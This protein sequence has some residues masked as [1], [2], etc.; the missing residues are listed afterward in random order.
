LK[1]REFL[2]KAAIG[3]AS[4]ASLPVLGGMPVAQAQAEPSPTAGA[5][6]NFHF[7]CSSRA[8]TV[9]NVKHVVFMTGDGKFDENGII[10]GGVYDHYDDTSASPKTILSSGPW[11]AK[12]LVSSNII[13]R[14]WMITAG[15][16]EMEIN[17]LQEKPSPAVIPA[18]LKVACNWPV[19]NLFVPN[20]K[21]GIT[22][23]IPDSDFGPFVPVVPPVGFTAFSTDK[24]AEDKA[25]DDV[26]EQLQTT[27]GLYLPTA[28]IVPSVIA[29]GLAFALARSR[30]KK[31][32]AR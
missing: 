27:S 19:G 16:A 26:K 12:R 15:V 8:G 25:L 6:V 10:G 29:G 18:T 9:A 17:L 20:E 31:K 28:A 30:R 3:T 1:R 13:G 4:L 7:V 24:R 14:W 22:L 32:N 2:K 11:E 21:E 5:Q 23:T